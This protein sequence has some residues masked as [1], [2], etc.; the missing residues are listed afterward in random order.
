MIAALELDFLQKSL[1]I[2]FYLFYFKDVEHRIFK[3]SRLVIKLVR[4]VQIIH[5]RDNFPPQIFK[6]TLTKLSFVSTKT[7]VMSV[8]ISKT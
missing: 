7:H 1:N 6:E 4:T 3:N 2:S 5:D 8:E